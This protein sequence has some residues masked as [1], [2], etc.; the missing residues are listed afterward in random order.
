MA[1][2]PALPSDE[3][4]TA[5]QDAVQIRRRLAAGNPAAYESDLARSLTDLSVDL[6]D[7]GRRDEGLTAI[8]DAV[9]IRRRLADANPAAYEPDLA[10]SLNNLS[11]YLGEA[12]RREEAEHA[13]REAS[14]LGM[15]GTQ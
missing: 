4:L 3:A 7:A 5:S 6:A 10:T 12:G 15:F 14:E 9:E 8:Q 1:I 13:S 11:F 2:R